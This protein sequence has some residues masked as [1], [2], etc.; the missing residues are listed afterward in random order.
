ML[1]AVVQGVVKVIDVEEPT[2]TFP[3]VWMGASAVI[4]FV[5]FAW[6]PRNRPVS[7]PERSTVQM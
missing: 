7:S 6:R 3:L 2:A 5:V 1:H 4:P